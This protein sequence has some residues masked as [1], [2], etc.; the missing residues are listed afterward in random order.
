MGSMGNSSPSPSPKG[1][2]VDGSLVNSSAKNRSR[3]VSIRILIDL[4]HVCSMSGSIAKFHILLKPSVQGK[5]K[6][7]SFAKCRFGGTVEGK[8][9][10][11]IPPRCR[12][13]TRDTLLHIPVSTNFN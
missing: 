11:V 4:S 3:S 2:N 13:A 10:D 1:P 8:P 9:Y 12:K 6:H 7:F 5:R